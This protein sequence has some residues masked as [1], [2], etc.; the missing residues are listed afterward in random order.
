MC[1]VAQASPS[2][3]EKIKILIAFLKIPYILGI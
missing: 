3:V 1:I 2:F